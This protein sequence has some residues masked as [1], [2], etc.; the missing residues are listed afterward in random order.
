MYKNGKY[1]LH[2]TIRDASSELQNNL[3]AQFNQIPVLGLK[4]HHGLQAEIRGNPQQQCYSTSS[5]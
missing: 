3:K 5:T 4:Y 2:K 1:D